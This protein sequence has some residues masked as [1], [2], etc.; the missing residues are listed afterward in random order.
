MKSLKIFGKLLMYA[1]ILL[2]SVLTVTAEP[3]GPSNINP[4]GSSRYPVSLA[5][6]TSAI[7]GNVTE[8]DFQS[9]SVTNTWQGYYGNISGSI[10]LGNSDN[11]T[12][13]DWTTAS[14]NGEIYATRATGVPAWVTI[15]CA[16]STHVDSEDATL[17]VNQTS[18]QDSVNRTFLNTTS[19]NTFFVGNL[20]INTSQNCYAVNL[21]NSSSQPSPN[22]QE[23]LLYDGS[24]LVYATVIS[25]DALGFDNRTHDFEMI[26]GE[27][28]HNGNSEPTPYYFYV[29]LG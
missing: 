7:A 13:Y 14:P 23:V 28:G 4:I 21:H 10:K 1:C 6:N 24:E 22:F 27:D 20:N 17:N 25:Q 16:N 12:L 3:T 11:Q 5:S 26:V 9:N 15:A 19:F 2:L 8:L 18:D 29:E